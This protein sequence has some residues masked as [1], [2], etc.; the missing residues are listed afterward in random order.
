MSKP[1]L[2]AGSLAYDRIMD[3][4]GFF[5]DHFLAD[6]LHNINV[7]FMVSPPSVQFGGTGANIAY[8]LKLL[9]ETADIAEC[10]GN[11]FVPFAD[12]LKTLGIS[13]DLIQIH[14]DEPTAS[15]FIITD[16]GDNQ[17]TAFSEGAHGKKYEKNID[18]SKYGVALIGTLTTENALYIAGVCN[19][20]GLPYFFDPGQKITAYTTEELKQLTDGAKILFMNDYELRLIS[21]KTGWGE[22][23]LA[24][25]VDTLIITLGGEGSRVVTKDSEKKIEAAPVPK[26][27]DPTG[28]GDAYRAGFL[29]GYVLGLPAETCAKMGSVAGAYCVEVYGTQKHHFTPDEFKKR[30]EETYHETVSF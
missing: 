26:I 9:G 25:N 3:F 23:D 13:T 22:S 12:N 8:T 11:D 19:K 21:D 28:A 30:Y 7:S 1:I 5:R 27:V 20:G 24:K 14:E 18:A 4:P 2:V 10:A 6:H 17:I 16:Q 15:A 29:K